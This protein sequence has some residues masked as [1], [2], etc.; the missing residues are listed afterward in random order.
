MLAI[1]L[2]C[3]VVAGPADLTPQ[4]KADHVVDLIHRDWVLLSRGRAVGLS[5]R[6]LQKWA[7]FQRKYRG[8]EIWAKCEPK[9]ISSGKGAWIL[10]IRSACPGLAIIP[11]RDSNEHD[12]K[13]WVEV[14]GKIRHFSYLPFKNRK[15]EVEYY[16]L[17]TLE[18]ESFDLTPAKD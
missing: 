15:G 4:Q 3:L 17:I 6:S 2:C 13:K 14:T 9:K 7:L 5:R 10:R 16:L 12:P 18:R 8:Q 11:P 1:F